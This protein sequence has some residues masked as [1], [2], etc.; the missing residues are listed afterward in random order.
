MADVDIG[1]GG[2]GVAVLAGGSAPGVPVGVVRDSEVSERAKR[3]TYTAEYR[4]GILRDAD[5]CTRPGEIG[6][7]LRREGLYSSI[8][9]FWRQQRNR[10]A[11]TRRSG[12]RPG[13]QGLATEGLANRIRTLEGEKAAWQEARTRLERNLRRAETIIEIQKKASELLG[14]PLNAPGSDEQG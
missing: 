2:S 5:R 1:T 12:K 9:S 8:L 4:L 14:M 13:L 10:G 6:A 7:L 11:L 3:R